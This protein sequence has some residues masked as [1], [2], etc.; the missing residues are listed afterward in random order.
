MIV[1]LTIIVDSHECLDYRAGRYGARIAQVSSKKKTK[2]CDIRL[3]GQALSP[4]G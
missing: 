2:Y 1:T 3:M 4:N